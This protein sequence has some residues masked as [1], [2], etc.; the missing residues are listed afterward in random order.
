MSVT[1][2]KTDLL[3]K[4]PRSGVR[5]LYR[6]KKFTKF[7]MATSANVED[8][9]EFVVFLDGNKLFNIVLVS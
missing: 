8:V 3:N 9:I 7:I 5:L 1:F 2:Y 4:L 6:C